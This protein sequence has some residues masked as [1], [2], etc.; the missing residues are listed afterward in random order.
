MLE[1]AQTIVQHHF[2]RVCHNYF[3]HPGSRSIFGKICFMKLPVTAICLMLFSLLSKY[4]TARQSTGNTPPPGK[5]KELKEVIVSGKKPA[6]EH[7]IDRTVV[8]VDALMTAAGGSAMDAL[9]KSPGVMV[10]VDGNIQL[11]GKGNVLVLIDDRPTYLSA[12]DLAAYL[13]SLPA[14]T[15][16]KIELISNPPAKYEAT[17]GAIINLQLKKNRLPGLNGNVSM[18]YSQGVY[19]RNNEALNLNFRKRKINLFTSISYGR[20]ANYT[21]DTSRRSYY[22]EDGTEKGGIAVYRRN[23]YTS[24]SVNGRAGLDYSISSKTTVGILIAGGIRP[25]KDRLDFNSYQT[26]GNGGPD[27]TGTGQ[28]RG[29]YQWRSGSVNLNLQHKLKNNTGVLSGDLDHINVYANGSQYSTAVVNLPDNSIS[30]TNSLLYYLPADI[31]IW[32]AKTDYNQT[33]QKRVSIE[34][35]LKSSYVV[36]DYQNDWYNKFGNDFFPDLSRT[37]HFIYGENVN[38]VYASGTKEGKR[39]SIK[40]GFRIE[41]TRIHGRQPGNAVKADSS[42]KRQYTNLFPSLYISRKL[43][44]TGNNR[45]T[46]SFGRRIRRPDYQQLNPF[47]YYNDR[48]SYAAGNPYLNPHYLNGLELI[49]N[50]KNT[51]GAE[52]AYG[53]ANRLIQYIVQAEDDLFITRPQNFGRNSTFNFIS[54]L[55]VDAVKGWRI[56]ANMRMFHLVNKGMANGLVIDNTINA[57]EIEVGNQFRFS[58]TW[59]A[60]LNGFYATRHLG[61]QTQTEAFWHMNAGVQKMIL[62]NKVTVRLNMN[63]IFHTIVRRNTTIGLDDIK[64]TRIIENDTRRIGISVN[65]RFGKETNNRR[66]NHD[67]GAAEEQGR[68]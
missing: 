22:N 56:N 37:N 34:A 35:G 41:N 18:G 19:G 43:D 21:T 49:Y 28:M 67:S 59:S 29:D 48:Y 40:A 5:P 9:S 57:G 14:A 13:Q 60:E 8:H 25:K 36:T 4:V 12:R 32:S 55:S 66:R 51:F 16:E 3:S 47:V 11:K 42:F 15:I 26:G 44:S 23:S 38:A 27:S 45:I 62:K 65:Y 10:D 1:L 68:M 7:K 31:Q 58:E 63:D 6:V 53:Y 61:G 52:I 33:L 17:G 64:A 20:D 39:W 50:H 24:N 46:L 30:S 54:W 2:Y